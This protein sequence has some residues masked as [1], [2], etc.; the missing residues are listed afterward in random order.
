MLRYLPRDAAPLT[1]ATW[2]A[3][4]QTVIG[5]ARSQL[6][7]R[8]LLEIVGPLGLGVRTI[9][10]A[11][12][13]A[14]GEATFHQARATLSSAATLS[15]PLLQSSFTLA[16]RDLAAAE[17]VGNPLDLAEPALA[18][19]ATARLEDQLVFWG[20]PELQIDGWVA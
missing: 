1:D 9:G 8:R 13:A 12:R 18:A 20:N 15:L 4:E 11:E 7:G 5:A 6:A 10:K 2:Q 19:I 14:E 17:E 16:I 3:L